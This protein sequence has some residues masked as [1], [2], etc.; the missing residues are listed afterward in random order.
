MTKECAARLYL[1]RVPAALRRADKQ[2]KGL[3]AAATTLSPAEETMLAACIAS[4]CIVL[5]GVVALVPPRP[6]HRASARSLS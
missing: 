4:S 1:G 5:A 6:A 2:P 3:D